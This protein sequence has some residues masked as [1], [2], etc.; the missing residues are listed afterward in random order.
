MAGPDGRG[1]GSGNVTMKVRP[2]LRSRSPGLVIGPPVRTTICSAL[3]DCSTT[4]TRHDD[5]RTCPRTTRSGVVM[6]WF[7]LAGEVTTTSA[8]AGS[9]VGVAAEAAARPEGPGL[10]V[11]ASAVSARSSSAPPA[12][13]TPTTVARMS[14]QT[15]I[16]NRPGR[17][18]PAP[19][20]PTEPRNRVSADVDEDVL[21]LRVEVERAHPELPADAGHLVAAEW[22]LRMDRAV[23]VHA[24]HAGLQRLR[25]AQRLADIAAPDGATEA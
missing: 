16:A 12:R 11:G 19:G 1:S 15:A 2:G 10:A 4:W 7:A 18:R 17:R 20:P 9:S 23:R 6:T 3:R 25:R 5:S 22:R 21:R 8:K 14:P 24:D 13:A